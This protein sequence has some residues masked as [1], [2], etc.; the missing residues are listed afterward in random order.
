MIF[1]A[2]Y[3]PASEDYLETQKPEFDTILCLR[4]TKWIHLNFGDEGIKMAFKRMFAQ[5]RNGGHLILEFQPWFTYSTSKR[6]TSQH[7]LSLNILKT[8]EAEYMARAAYYC[9]YVV[10]N[11]AAGWHIKDTS[12][13]RI[14]ILS[15]V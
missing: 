1:E 9:H 5:L 4:V 14:R 12:I 3:V 6:I 8:T 2:N 15:K 13:L 11:I 10:I 7:A